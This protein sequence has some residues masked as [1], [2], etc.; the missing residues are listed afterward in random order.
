VLDAT[1]LPAGAGYAT[2][3]TMTFRA[4]DD[5]LQT[6]HWRAGGKDTSFDVA[7]KRARGQSKLP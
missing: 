3:M 6:W 5:V 4:P 2:S 1:N 7:L